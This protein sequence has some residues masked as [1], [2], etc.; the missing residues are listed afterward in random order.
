MA[1]LGKVLIASVVIELT[2]YIVYIALTVIVLI[3]LNHSEFW[4]PH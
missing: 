1:T 4:L 3:Y 2:A